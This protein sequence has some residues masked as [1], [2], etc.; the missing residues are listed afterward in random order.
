MEVIYRYFTYCTEDL[1]ESIATGWRRDG[2]KH[3]PSGRPIEIL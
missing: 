1:G 3:R 2:K